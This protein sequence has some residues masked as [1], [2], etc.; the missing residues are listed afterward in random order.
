MPTAPRAEN[1]A[2]ALALRPCPY[3]IIGTLLPQMGPVSKAICHCNG[4]IKMAPTG[5]VI[6]AAFASRDVFKLPGFEEVGERKDRGK[7]AKNKSEEKNKRSISRANRRVNELTKCNGDTFD[8]FVTL[9]L[10]AAE[11]NRYE[12]KEIIKKLNKWLSNRVERKGLAY[13]LVPELHK[14]GAIHF[15]GFVNSSALTLS[16]SGRKWKGKIVYN[17]KDWK[18]GF[19]T[20]VKLT[21]SYMRACN[22]ILKYVKKQTA[23]GMIGGR[24]YLHGGQL[25]EPKVKYV[26]FLETPEGKRYDIEDASMFMVYVTDLSKCQWE[27]AEVR[28]SRAATAVGLPNE[29]P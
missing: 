28:V 1:R 14:D 4:R 22:Y 2:C 17:V 25:Q 5:E 6:E 12:W 13:L 24:Y 10:D 8:T 18:I 21:G 7:S 11:C 16:D 27:E 19:T 26:R 15:H 3:L 29:V 23:G 9:T 20:A